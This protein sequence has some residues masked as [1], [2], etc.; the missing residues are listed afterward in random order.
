MKKQ[1][2]QLKLERKRVEAA[3]RQ[4]AHDS[5]TLE[6]KLEKARNAP[7]NSSR[8]IARLERLLNEQKS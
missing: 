3:D 7:G 1:T 5:L 4:A 8:E 2:R 6:Q